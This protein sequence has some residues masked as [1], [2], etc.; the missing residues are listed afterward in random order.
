MPVVLVPVVVA[1]LSYALAS[2]SADLSKGA[3]VLLIVSML[4]GAGAFLT[5]ES[6]EETV[7][8][9]AEVSP[10]GTATVEVELRYQPI[11]FRWVQNLGAYDAPEPRRFE[12]TPARSS[13]M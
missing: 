9:I 2:K 12:G 1:M 8:Q 3:L 6:A 10:A 5:G 13:R 11:A 4:F 7:E